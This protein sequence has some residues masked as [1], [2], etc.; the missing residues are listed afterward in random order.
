MSNI[1]TR[2]TGNNHAQTQEILQQRAIQDYAVKESMSIAT[3]GYNIRM[4]QG[5]GDEDASWG[6][7][8]GLRLKDRPY[9][10]FHRNTIDPNV[11]LNYMDAFLHECV[12][13]GRLDKM[14]TL[15]AI[16][17]NRTGKRVR[18]Q[19]VP[20]S[21]NNILEFS[22]SD[23]HIEGQEDGVKYFWLQIGDENNLLPNEQGYVDFGQL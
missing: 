21:E 18:Y 3:K 7:T 17:N 12:R 1:F 23:V 9:C 22:A 15:S 13:K 11:M 8:V 16:L 2:L 6:Y 14:G 19:A 10:L 20:L 5:T 4:L